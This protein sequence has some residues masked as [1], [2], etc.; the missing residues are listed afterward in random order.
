MVKT[1]HKVKTNSVRSSMGSKSNPIRQRLPDLKGLSKTEIFEKY[2][3]LGYD[4]GDGEISC[5]RANYDGI[6]VYL[7]E[8][9]FRNGAHVPNLLAFEEDTARLVDENY[10]RD[11]SVKVYS[12]FK[13]CPGVGTGDHYNQDDSKL[14]YGDLMGHS[15]ACAIKEL[16]DN[17]NS[18]FEHGNNLNEKK[19]KETFIL[20]GR[21]SSKG[22]EAA[23]QEYEAILTKYLLH[24]LPDYADRITVM[25]LSESL[26]AMADTLTMDRKN[27]CSS[28]IQILDLGSSTF[29]LT[30]VTPEGLQ[31]K[32]EDSYQFGG[33]K[34]DGAMVAYGDYEFYS[35]T[36]HKGC[37]IVPDFG[38]KADLR[39]KKELCYG[40]NGSNLDKK[41]K[42]P[43][44][45]YTYTTSSGEEDYFDFKIMPG[46]MK[47]ICTNQSGLGDLHCTTGHLDA[48]HKEVT[49]S[50]WINACTYVMQQ[51]YNQTQELYPANSNLP[52]RLIL[53]GGVSNMPEVREIAKKI[54]H[55]EEAELAKKP[56]LTVS[57]GL[58]LILGNEIIK[59]SILEELLQE[60]LT[61]DGPLPDAATMLDEI[62][63][64]ATKV[65]LDY[66]EKIIKLW[67]EGSSDRT[68]RYCV[69]MVKDERNSYHMPDVRIVEQAC[70]NWISKHRIEESVENTL[71]KKFA[72]MFPDFDDNKFQFNVSLPD[73][74]IL[75]E[76]KLNNNHP[77]NLYM[78]LD[79]TNYPKEIPPK[80]SLWDISFSPDERQKI[81]QVYRGHRKDLEVGGVFDCG[82]G[83]QVNILG[84]NSFYAEQLKAS[85][86]ESNVRD[87]LLEKLK[88]VITDFVDKLTYYLIAS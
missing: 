26:A 60:L 20:V 6:Q 63:K 9:E 29:D 4:N 86:A 85:G 81:L 71:K 30:T 36:E 45:T 65:N 47:K 28:F 52:R 54:F 3:F 32:G 82:D 55:V 49:H 7:N 79:R 39:F 31:E 19:F 18:L 56:S 44:Y 22:W 40:D 51:F 76:F 77:F 74:N 17:N 87:W 61:E 48:L 8:L 59:K 11:T 25:V 41:L 34:L 37:T 88:P 12:N 70:A 53:T 15:F 13:C 64:V 83:R 21:P 66:Y 68:L 1:V 24:Y 84:Y 57:N 10:L 73:S 27:W 38:Q 16:L 75:Q 35:K 69:E 5:S 23:E 2:N 43:I 33:N 72:Q 42:P 80:T 58:A 50:S 62:S 14:T 67:A 46:V 78:F